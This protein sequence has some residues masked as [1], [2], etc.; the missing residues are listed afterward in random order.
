MFCKEFIVLCKEFIVLCKESAFDSKIS[1][2]FKK[3]M[4]YYLLLGSNEGDKNAHLA[5]AKKQLTEQLGRIEQTSHIYETAAWG[6]VSQ[7]DYYN[8]AICINS[9]NSPNEGL[10]II[11]NI[12]NAMGRKRDANNKNA[13]RTIDIDILMID[14]K[15]IDTPNLTVPHPRLHERSFALLPLIEIAGEVVH[16]VLQLELDDV[17]EQCTDEL[18]VIMV[19]N[20]DDDDV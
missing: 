2:N 13:A 7:P 12:E 19:D 9:K 5:Q 10:K 20:D 11:Q 18:E 16:P 8:Q 3:T 14:D 17:Y 6:D 4:L 1:K 15:I